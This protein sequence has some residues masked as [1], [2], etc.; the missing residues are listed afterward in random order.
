[1]K[2]LPKPESSGESDKNTDRS[3]VNDQIRIDQLE[4]DTM[5]ENNDNEPAPSWK[6][7]IGDTGEPQKSSEKVITD[8]EDKDRPDP[9]TPLAPPQPDLQQE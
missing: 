8:K 3:K 6:G 9:G 1:M 7:E 4:K 5:I 2:T